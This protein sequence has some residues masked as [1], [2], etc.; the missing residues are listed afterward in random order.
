MIVSPEGLVSY[1]DYESIDVVTDAKRDTF[2]RAYLWNTSNLLPFFWFPRLHSAM[3]MQFSRLVFLFLTIKQLKG[4]I[5]HHKLGGLQ[6]RCRFARCRNCI[7][8]R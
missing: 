8:C 2:L 4:K 5:S 6:R 3:C 1:Q 7:V